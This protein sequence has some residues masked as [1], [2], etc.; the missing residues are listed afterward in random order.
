LLNHK[1]NS[2]KLF[3]SFCKQV[4]ILLGTVTAKGSERFVQ[5]WNLKLFRLK[6]MLIEKLIMMIVTK[7]QTCLPKGSLKLVRPNKCYIELSTQCRDSAR[8]N[9]AKPIVNGLLF[10]SSISF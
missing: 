1:V 6:P 8:P 4:S 3:L 7:S 5:V 10:L 9:I 2:I